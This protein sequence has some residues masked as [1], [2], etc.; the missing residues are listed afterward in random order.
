MRKYIPTSRVNPCPVCGDTRGRCRHLPDNP[1][2]V[3]CMTATDAY[4][5]PPP[6]QFLKL[7]S[8][9]LW[10]IVRRDTKDVDDA[11]R[12]EWAERWRSMR[13]ERLQQEKAH[14]AASLTEG[15]RDTQI[16]DILVQ[17]QLCS[18]HREDLKRR[19]LNDELIAAGLFKSVSQW[20]KLDQE[21]SYQ[22]AGVA[23]GG[24]S[25]ITPQSGYL[26]PV[27][28]PEGQIVGWQL[29]VDDKA[30][31]DVP[32]YLWGTSR[33]RKRPQGATV[34]LKNGEL[35]LTFCTPV[36]EVSSRVQY[37]GLAEG[38][39]KPWIIAQLRNQITIGASGGNFAG[40][41]ETLKRYLTAA[42]ERLGGTLD[43]V[44]WADAGAIANKNVMR[45]YR[46]TYELVTRWGYTL[47][48]AWYG[49]L[50]KS[51]ADPDEY[52]GE[53]ELLTWAQFESLSR[54]PLSI[55]DDVTHQLNKIKR[56]LR[57]RRG[58][59]Q[60]KRP[61]V[62]G[63]APQTIF[64]YTPTDLPTPEQYK[65]LGCPKIIYLGD[66]RVSIWLEAVN[67]GWQH[68]L[69]KS[70]PGLGKS[71]TAGSMTAEEFGS[72]QL[73]YLASDHRNPT[74]LTVE[75]NFV[76]LHPRHS[77]FAR[78]TT[79]LTP[80]GQPFLV[81]PTE[82]GDFSI[83]PGNCHRAG[84]FRAL[85]AKNINHIEE[86]SNP[87]CL[88]CHLYNACC[89][90]TGPGFGYRFQR[91]SV[92]QY[93]LVRAHPDSLPDPEDYQFSESGI[94]WD[95]A[96]QVMRSH[97]KI[98]VTISD[99]NQTVG[100]LS[101]VAPS[102]YEKLKTI[103]E[104]LR[105]LLWGDTYGQGSVCKSD[106]PPPNATRYGYNDTTIRQLLGTPPDDLADII[107]QLVVKLSPNLEFLAPCADSVD[108]SV[109]TKAERATFRR[110]NKLLR[111]TANLEIKQALEVVPLNWLVPL[112]E[113]WGRYFRGAMHFD[114]GVLVIHQEDTRH[115][116]VAQ[117]AQY[118]IYLDGTLDVRYLALKLGVGVEDVLLIEQ[119]TPQ[120]ENLTVAQ[121][122]DMGVLGRDR[123][124]SMHQRVA[125]LRSEIEKLSPSVAFIERKSYAQPG[126]G[127]HFRDGRGVNRFA[128]ATAVAS[129]G[130][131]YPNIG[132]LAAEYQVLTGVVPDISVE[133]LPLR[134]EN[135][136]AAKFPDID[137]Q[138]FVDG[139]VSAEILQ[140]V[141][142]LRSHLRPKEEL[143]YYF[144]GDFDV[145]FLQEELPGC[146]F[147]RVRAIEI[148][149]RAAP[150]CEQTKF[151][152]IKAIGLH[153]LSGN[154]KPTQQDVVDEIAAVLPKQKVIKQPRVS[155]IAAE[156]IIGGWAKLLGAVAS[157]LASLLESNS[158][159]DVDDDQAWVALV[160]LPLVAQGTPLLPVVN[161]VQ[162]ASIV[163]NC[164][165][166]ILQH[167][168]FNVRSAL[169][170]PQRQSQ[171]LQH[172]FS[173]MA[174]IITGMAW[175][176]EQFTSLDS[177]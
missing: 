15:D 9:G 156:I 89:H 81:H 70:A 151:A 142:R 94:F 18:D 131:P 172:A 80:L 73:W 96:T 129:V 133:E 171:L 8:D 78:D 86:S 47:Q 136:A 82:K 101:L 158:I 93:P 135:L 1:D 144:V 118:N 152:L 38:I 7:T 31:E 54:N 124:E 120:Y 145:G 177:S 95:E 39:L 107:N 160:Y 122:T 3:L 132:E 74:T 148:D 52:T 91:H 126:D 167:V 115:R 68:I 61:R 65:R 77:G 105:F 10:G 127:Y 51:C 103:F 97:D 59:A 102:L 62:T 90:S 63:S 176:I 162:T 40:S 139:L 173:I 168:A 19:G 72:R 34:H 83:T 55:W 146:K 161:L 57:P 141:G 36:N 60:L 50:D 76:D 26:C 163:G 35:P 104:L 137:F 100:E 92:L 49:Q 109:G 30:P 41:P 123:R 32:K 159:P 108:A 2:T 84:T 116:D 155:Q 58:F 42:K 106:T 16:R 138:E 175:I 174:H 143:I 48:V 140:E 25:L 110:I 113:V 22:L 24:R 14:L 150:C 53:Y 87:I 20:Q 46:R 56:L 154:E 6:W 43:V 64:V 169:Q 119:V 11:S 79:R 4:S 45:Q 111:S 121:I 112:L 157:I 21:V 98:E 66:E 117:A 12:R 28:N 71:H 37:I 130:I 114:K 153:I 17:L 13:I 5:A 99:F 23:L 88:S 75:T 69:D 165:F 33:T 164:F 67:K 147:Q 125:A 27:W 85:A 170:L 166:V 134:E 128:G 44:L 29:R 149:W